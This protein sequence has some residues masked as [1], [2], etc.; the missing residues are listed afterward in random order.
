MEIRNPH[1][2]L[3]ACRSCGAKAGENCHFIHPQLG[4]ESQVSH[5]HAARV[6]DYAMWKEGL[7]HDGFVS[8]SVDRRL[9][10]QTSY[11]PK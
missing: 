5:P 6:Y 10:A 4:L 1:T 3:I 7:A 9:R 2:L 8:R 11:D